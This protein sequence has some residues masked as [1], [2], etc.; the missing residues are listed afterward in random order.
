MQ[1]IK[2]LCSAFSYCV[3]ILDSVY[4]WY[5]RGSTSRERK[6]AL[7]YAEAMANVSIPPIE[8][9]EGENDGD[10]LFWLILGD[11]GYAK[12]DYWRWRKSSANIEPSISK[13]DIG[14][15]VPFVCQFNSQFCRSHYP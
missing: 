12:A 6:A 8:L 5:G 7:Q 4:V 13:V 14:S 3:T 15:G 9:S 2:D 10:E 11:D 1:N